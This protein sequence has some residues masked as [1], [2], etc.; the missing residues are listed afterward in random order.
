MISKKTGRKKIAFSLEALIGIAFAIVLICALL[1][2]EP[3][4]RANVTV[5]AGNVNE[6]SINQF[7]TKPELEVEPVTDITKIDLSHTGEHKVEFAFKNNNYTSVLH[8]VDTTPPTAEP[9]NKEIYVGETLTASD[10]VTNIK[11]CSQVTVEFS[12]QPEFTAEGEQTVNITLTDSFENTSQITAKLNVIKDTEPP[13]F[14]ELKAISVQIGN[15]V[16]YRKGVTVTDNRDEKV[17]YTFDSSSVDL[18]KEGEYKVVYIATDSAGNTATAERTVKVKAKPVIDEAYVKNLA[19]EVTDTIITQN[20]T[21]HQ[22]IDAIFS[23]VRKNMVYVSS[24]ETELVDAAYVG[25][26]K[27]QGDCYNYYSVTK[28]LLDQCGIQNMKVDRYGGSTSHYWHLVNIGTG[29]YHYDT[30][31]QSLEDPYR[32]FMKTNEQVWAYAKSRH[33]GRSDYYNFDES[34]YPAVATEE[35]TAN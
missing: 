1:P 34:K 27:R 14:E 4:V 29:W 8:I 21:A 23:W 9:V 31:P 19:K 25:F 6:L 2:K 28:L 22:K 10:F 32:C 13:K 20:M 30:T 15:S 5:E 16:S 12:E 24:P 18:Q 11:D 17:E 26:K 7:K 3:P 35:Y 33:D